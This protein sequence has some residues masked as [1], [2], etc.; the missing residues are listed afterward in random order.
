[1]KA[2]PH[3][4]PRLLAIVL[5][6]F[7]LQPP[8]VAMEPGYLTHAGQPQA[9]IIIREAP[10]RSLRLAAGELQHHIESIS[11]ARLEVRSTPSGEVPYL[12]FVGD[13]P[14][15]EA[16][17]ISSDGLQFGAFRIASGENW[18][19]LVGNDDDFV[20]QEPWARN[21]TAVER[22][23]V[24]AEWDALTG[25]GNYWGGAD[26]SLYREYSPALDLW[27]RDQRG[28]LNAVYELLRT[29]GMRWY[30][31]GE[32]GKV[33]PSLPDLPLPEINATHKPDFDMRS[34][35][36][37]MNPFVNATAANTNVL[38]QIKWELWLGNTHRGVVLGAGVSGHGNIAVHNREEVK[39][40]HPEYYA[41]WGGKRATEHLSNY[42]AACLSSPG[43]FDDNLSYARFMFDR[44]G[45]PAINASPADGYTQLCQC[46]LCEGKASSELGWQGQL[47][48]YVWAYVNNLA[49]ELYQTHPD[50]YVTGIA[51]GTFLVPPSNID[52]L[53][54]NVVVGFCYWRSNFQDPER[55]DTFRQL[56]D[57]WLE[58]TPS[59]QFYVW[60]YYLHGRPGSAYNNVPVYFTRA[61]AED[62]QSLKGI[63][64][65]DYIEVYGA[66]G[67]MAFNHL[68][69]YVTSRFQWDAERDLDALLDEFYQLFYGPAASE[70]QAFVEFAE[71]N[72]PQANRDIDVIDQLFTLLAAAQLAAEDDEPLY[73]QRIQL[74]AD[75]M[76]GLKERRDELAIGRQDDLLVVA[77]NRA[78]KLD[79]FTFDGKL[80]DPFWQD[81]PVHSL[82]HNTT[83]GEPKQTTT[84]RAAWARGSLYL[85][86]RCEESEMQNLTIGTSKDGDMNLFSGDAVEILIETP[87]HAHYQ[88]AISP[89]GAI[90]DLD[91]RQGLNNMWSS[92]AEIAA[93]QGPDYWSLEIRIPA[94]GESVG[95]I[96][97][98]NGVAGNKPT[99]DAPWHFNVCR[100]RT[101][102]D[103]SQRE[104]SALAPTGSSSFH[105][106]WFFARIAT[107]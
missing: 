80:D 98:L 31:P 33:V 72:W 63:S 29:L 100:M 62:L 15:T 90:V 88:L 55:R 64:R 103:R 12:I 53:S 105:L 39:Q 49:K 1:M 46:E 101:G 5:A 75:Y 54:P 68:N 19:A 107:D 13:S 57:D 34:M 22:E 9:E 25:E 84:V 42:G 82:R 26:L 52:Q 37:W 79:G 92:N 106:P 11:G 17:G 94:A 10:T 30:Y 43:L 36:V 32:L 93:H 23:R 102:A 78:E 3:F 7:Y 58:I 35:W 96:D 83:G 76:A 74:L 66:G 27:E 28:S 70:M 40:A 8:V 71:A 67:A 51:Y 56:R 20:P 73:S 21:H 65:G 44:R 60:D 45:Q 2:K 18:L 77:P 59:G 24:N 104:A 81:L 16:L 89:S 14:H 61:I 95:D 6:T 50:H 48:N 85:G 41:L 4:I 99:L 38:D 69:C 47:S 91:R 97:P 87:V 86:I